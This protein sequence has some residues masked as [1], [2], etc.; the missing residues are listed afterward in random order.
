ML[1]EAEFEAAGNKPELT[2]DQIIQ[3]NLAD[4]IRSTLRIAK[5]IKPSRNMSL[6]ITNLENAQDK[7]DRAIRGE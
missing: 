7:L 2:E 5:G 6:V 4:L 1:S 3:Q